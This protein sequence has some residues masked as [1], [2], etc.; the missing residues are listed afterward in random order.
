MCY[1]YVVA[2]ACV[3]SMLRVVTAM[4]VCDMMFDASSVI[5]TS[6]DSQVHAVD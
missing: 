5:A 2:V 4:K 6:L 1:V 3:V